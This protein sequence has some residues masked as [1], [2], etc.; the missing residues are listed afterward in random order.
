MLNCK[1]TFSLRDCVQVHFYIQY[2]GNTSIILM[3]ESI[4]AGS[5]R[6]QAVQRA[7]LRGSYQPYQQIKLECKYSLPH[8][9]KQQCSASKIHDRHNSVVFLQSHA[10]NDLH[11]LQSC[12]A[13]K[14][15]RQNTH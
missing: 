7:T 12:C 4:T 15:S 9:K 13:L 8:V 6:M 11:Q 14:S 5:L 10:R 1:L 3:P 2:T